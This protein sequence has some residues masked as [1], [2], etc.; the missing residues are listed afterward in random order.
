M[1]HRFQGYSNDGGPMRRNALPWRPSLRLLPQ[2]CCLPRR[3]LGA[4]RPGHDPSRGA[5]VHRRRPVHRQLRLPGRRQRLPRPGRALLRHRRQTETDGCTSGSL[6]I[7]TPVEVTGASQ[8]GT[9]AYNSWLTMQARN[10][11]DEDTCAFNDLALI[12]IDPADVPNVNPSVPGFGGPTGVGSVGG[13]RIDRLLL[14]EL[15]AARAAS[16]R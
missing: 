8:P 9:L 6:P 12:E 14:R 7:G 3:D 13:L 11:T 1:T 5:G 15:R 2:S 4:R 16:P 10:E